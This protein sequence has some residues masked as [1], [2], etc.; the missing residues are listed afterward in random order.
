M[1]EHKDKIIK[2]IKEAIPSKKIL[3][4]DLG[5]IDYNDAYDL[6]QNL[7]DHINLNPNPG[8]ILIL[9]H[10]PVITIGSNKNLG[11]LIINERKLKEQNIGLVQSTRGGDITLHAPG[12]IVCYPILNL[13]RIKKDL[14]LYVDNL[15]QVIINTLDAYEIIGKR[16]N[17][18]RGIFVSDFKIASIG[19]KIKKWVTLHGFSLNVNI[20]LKYFNNITACGLKDHPQ[21]SMEKILNKTIPIDDVKEQILI[22]FKKVFD[23]PIT[24]IDPEYLK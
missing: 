23:I 22:S 11:N 18:H 14:T 20:D 1:K 13:S 19:L 3:S 16:V 6:Q 24:K 10:A 21:T 15:E 5:V 12:Q 17:K 7:Y 4:F 8:V 9:E 2:Y